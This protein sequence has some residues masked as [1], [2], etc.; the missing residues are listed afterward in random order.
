M[1]SKYDFF[2]NKTEITHSSLITESK[3]CDP[4]NKNSY[5]LDLNY[6][7]KEPCLKKYFH[8]HKQCFNFHNPQDIRRE[9]NISE[10]CNLKECKIQSNCERCHNNVEYLYHS[11]RYKTKFCMNF[12]DN[13]NKCEYGNFC[14]FAHS[15]N[16]ILT[17]LIHN[18]EFDQDF[19]M[20][21]YKTVWCP[22]NLTHHD[23]SLCVYAHN[24]QDFRR[25]PNEFNY[26]PIA[27]KMWNSKKII[28]KYDDG[29]SLSQNCFHCHGWKELEYHP[30]VYKTKICPLGGNCAQTKKHCPFYHHSNDER[31]FYLIFFN[32]FL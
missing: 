4:S 9:N 30:L 18:Y 15:E 31:F 24:W 22:F 14:S 13:L 32:F 3:D 19:F 28:L 27:C 7:K 21:H 2:K 11:D 5:H 20:F 25:K 12:P 6:F 10:Q 29:C 1:V 16:E 8:K 17:K 26:E 23:K